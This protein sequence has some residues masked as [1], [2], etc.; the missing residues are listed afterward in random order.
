LR[1]NRV[2]AAH[3]NLLISRFK[4]AVERKDMAAAEDLFATI[5]KLTPA[6]SRLGELRDLVAAGYG[7]KTAVSLDL[8]GGV[9]LPKSW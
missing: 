8:G 5:I 2:D 7:L 9:M 6:D 1:K 4:E 3:I